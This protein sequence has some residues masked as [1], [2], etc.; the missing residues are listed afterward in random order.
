[1]TVA[2]ISNNQLIKHVFVGAI[3]AFDLTFVLLLGFWFGFDS[4]YNRLY[5]TL[6]SPL[7]SLGVMTPFMQRMVFYS[8]LSILVG[9]T[10]YLSAQ[11]G[12]EVLRGYTVKA[13]LNFIQCPKCHTSFKKDPPP[14]AEFVIYK[15]DGGI[16][17]RTCPLEDC[18]ELW[19]E[20]PFEVEKK[21]APDLGIFDANV[22]NSPAKVIAETVSGKPAKEEKVEKKPRGRPKTLVNKKEKVITTENL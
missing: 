20:I 22:P 8:M 17:K 11:K 16:I 6:L 21:H 4:L 9:L 15:K 18:G 2:P 3:W 13:D 12:I 14:W 7:L 19:A 10:V 5:G 1:M